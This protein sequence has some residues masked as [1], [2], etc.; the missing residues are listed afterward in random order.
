MVLRSTGD[1]KVVIVGGAPVDAV[2]HLWWNVV[3]SDL[4]RI[5]QAA[6]DWQ[7]QRFPAVPGESEY[8]PLPAGRPTPP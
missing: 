6:A 7:A 1:G 4:A 3:S 5:D 2:R 8:I